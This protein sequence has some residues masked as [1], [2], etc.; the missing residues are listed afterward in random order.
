M[1]QPKFNERF[2]LMRDGDQG[3]ERA[4]AADPPAQPLRCLTVCQPWA[5]AI[6]EGMKNIENRSWQTKHRGPLLIHAGVSRNWFPLDEN[7]PRTFPDDSL[8]PHANQCLFGAILGM[9]DV[10][11][12]VKSGT[13]KGIAIMKASVWADPESGTWYWLLA[14]PRKLR[15]PHFCK[16]SLSL[17]PAPAD[18]KLE[19]S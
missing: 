10:V 11:D 4:P 12:C 14:N 15:E 9:V 8:I 5:H 13:K 17:W 18:L 6:M 16:G 19:F 2:M 1:R 7:E 3:I